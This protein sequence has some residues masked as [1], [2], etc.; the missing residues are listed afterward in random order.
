MKLK[1]TGYLKVHA[2]SFDD[3]F[4]FRHI[5]GSLKIYRKNVFA[6][7]LTNPCAKRVEA[8]GQLI[9]MPVEHL[10]S[11]LEINGVGH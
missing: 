7:S 4:A 3:D 9:A 8:G 1:F 6:A 2:K 5:L 11:C 10:T